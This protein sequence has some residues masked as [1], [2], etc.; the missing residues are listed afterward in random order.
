MLFRRRFD[1]GKPE[2]ASRYAPV[3]TPRKSCDHLVKDQVLSSCTVRCTALGGSS[4]TRRPSSRGRVNLRVARHPPSKHKLICGSQLH[5]PAD[6]CSCAPPAT[7]V[8]ISS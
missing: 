6:G 7:Q 3:N 8:T 1:R 2:L 5:G 4:A